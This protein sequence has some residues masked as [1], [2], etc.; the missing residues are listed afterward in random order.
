MA[1]AESGELDRVRSRINCPEIRRLGARLK[2]F[3][4]PIVCGLVADPALDKSFRA[5][6]RDGP[7][8]CQFGCSP[9]SMLIDQFIAGDTNVAGTP[10]ES[11]RAGEFT[12]LKTNGNGVRAVV[13]NGV[14]N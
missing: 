10:D 13:L 3:D 14:E 11:R 1:S 12:Q 5:C 6:H 9:L 8:A 7:G 4:G 2:D